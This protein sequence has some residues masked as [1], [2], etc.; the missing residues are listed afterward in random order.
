MRVRPFAFETV[1]SYADRLREA[2]FI[3]RTTWAIWFN[4]LVRLHGGDADE[5]RTQ[6]LAALGDRSLEH[7]E[8]DAGQALAHTDGQTCN[9]CETGLTARFGCRRCSG[10][11]VVTQVAHDGP[12]VC[13]RHRLWVGP[14]TDTEMQDVVGKDVVVADRHYQVM[15]RQGLLDTHRLTELL[16]CVDEWATAQTDGAVP[17]PERFRIAVELGRRI[18]SP[19]RLV[20]VLSSSLAAEERY[21]ALAAIVTDIVNGRASTVLTDA[22]WLLLRSLRHADGAAAHAF[23]VPNGIIESGDKNHLE[24]L[25]SC[26]YPRARHLHLVQYVESAFPGTRYSRLHFSGSVNTYA[27]VRG[28]RFESSGLGIKRSARTAGCGYCSNRKAL[29]GFNSLVDTHFEVSKE[30]HPTANSDLTPDQVVAGSDRTHYW[31]CAKGHTFTATVTARTSNGNGCGVCANRVIQAGV[32]SLAATRPDLSADWH[33]SLNGDL[34]PEQVSA[35]TN[36]KVWWRCPEGHDYPM[37]VNNRSRKKRAS[38]CSVCSGQRPDPTTCLATTHKAVARR[39]HKSKNGSLR[40]TDVIAG[41]TKKVWWQCERGHEYEAIVYTQT[42]TRSIGCNICLNRAV[43]GD[44]C[45]RATHAALAQQFHDSLNGDKTPDNVIASATAKFWWKCELG[46]EWQATGANR[47]KGTGCP[48]CAGQR[49]L[50]G[51]NDMATTNPDLAREW[52]RSRNP[53]IQPEDVRASTVRLLWWQCAKG[54]EWQARGAD[55]CNKGSGCPYC[56][57]QKVLVGFNDLMTTHPALG[58]EMHV[59]LNGDVTAQTITARSSKRLWWRCAEGHEWAAH[60]YARARSGSMCPEC[61]RAL[62][63]RERT[64]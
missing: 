4:S 49:V 5:T 3:D 42:R 33:P 26:A 16:G 34:T 39:W 18:M 13:R 7:R 61:R 2:N 44:N 43:S 8:R 31:L 28:H 36:R 21:T 63:R 20:V 48:Y 53:G 38:S 58:G 24:Q 23:V 37:A 19:S 12:R 9:K 54:H 45:M 14:G 17:A 47:V 11:A 10:G 57:N 15:R 40:P 29:A 59:S 62:R 22:V 25:R 6:L 52:H 64:R 1:A 51:W 46:H 55:R 27:C 35:G 30:W 41:S 50:T 56:A 32:N 60:A